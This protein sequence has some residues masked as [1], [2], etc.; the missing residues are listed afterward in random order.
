MKLLE[1]TYTKSGRVRVRRLVPRDHL[2]TLSTAQA[3]RMLGVGRTRFEQIRAIHKLRP[4]PS[5]GCPAN[6]YYTVDVARVDLIIS[7]G[8]K[9]REIAWGDGPDEYT[10]YSEREYQALRR[11]RRLRKR[12]CS[13]AEVAR[14]LGCAR[15]QVSRWLKH[16]QVM[17]PWA[18]DALKDAMLR[19]H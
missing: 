14:E 11:L 10:E 2:G 16:R 8:G 15:S 3:A 4:A 13:D 1:T 7:N 5:N 18:I 9:V 19:L 6:R 12:L 17:S